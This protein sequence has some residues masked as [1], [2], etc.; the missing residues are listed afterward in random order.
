M[1]L[2]DFAI[3]ERAKFLYNFR[4]APSV[5][6]YD[7][8]CNLHTYSLNRDPIYFKHTRFLVDRLHWRDHTGTDI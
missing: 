7:N 2:P 8:A 1:G 6:V 5:I 4:L 3:V